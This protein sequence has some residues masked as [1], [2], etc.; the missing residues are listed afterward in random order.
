[1]FSFG[2]LIAANSALY[3]T[4]LADQKSTMYDYTLQYETPVII[5]AGDCDWTTPYPM[6]VK[7]FNAISAPYKK[8]ITI[9]NTG[10]IPF[11]DRKKSFLKRCQMHYAMSYTAYRQP[12][13]ILHQ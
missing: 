11:I 4:L 13:F 2:S 5:I 9:R 3:E 7:Y 1:M 10:H 12:A 6:A 8:F